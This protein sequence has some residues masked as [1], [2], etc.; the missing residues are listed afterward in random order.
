M[1]AEHT[2]TP[3]RVL[4]TGAAGLIGRV[5]SRTL[6]ERGVAVTALVL[7]DPGDLAADRVVVGDAGDPE[8]VRKALA[9]VDAV[10]HLAA[11]PTPKHGTPL[12]VFGGNTRATFT[13]LE[14]AG[15]A[16]IRRA[17]I[18]SSFSIL[19][20]PWAHRA[21]H[22]AYLPIDEQLPLQI[23][24]PYGLS[25]RV[26]ECTA[27]AMA[28]RHGMTVVALRFPFVSDD[29]RTAFRLPLVTADP[30][31]AASELWT[32]LDVRDAAHAGWLALTEPVSGYH[33]V[34]VAA[35][36][37]L[38]PYR[39]DELIAAFHPQSELRRPLEGR[40]V[41]IDLTAAKRLLGFTAQHLV[42]L[43]VLPLPGTV[44]HA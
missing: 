26:D 22:P 5:V 27:E 16:G 19:G 40:E 41:P 37:T 11:M 31:E 20:L 14:E 32:Y 13:V 39:T 7:A 15:Q 9:D 18:A 42:E 23:E 34:F 4:V 24:D 8:L 2:T 21:L 17:V 10:V 6:A 44:P 25:K 28:Q 29:D 33:T 3:S 35:P 43:D 1:T 12:E 36:E 30:G 38:A